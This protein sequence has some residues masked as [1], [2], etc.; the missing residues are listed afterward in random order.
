MGVKDRR[1]LKS[2]VIEK[3]K[4]AIKKELA[5][6]K[7]EKKKVEDQVQKEVKPKKEIPV[8]KEQPIKQEHINEAI[9][10]VLS[11][12]DWDGIGL[13][14]SHPQ[15]TLFKAICKMKNKKL[16]EEILKMVKVFNE[17]N[18]IEGL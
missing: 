13:I 16:G 4:P 9:E 7:I 1:A 14:G 3:P 15:I 11:K 18:K 2:V 12:K 6:T 17:N 10:A 8:K 5:P